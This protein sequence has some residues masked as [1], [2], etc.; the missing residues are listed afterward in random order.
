L[1]E[2]VAPKS[3]LK[4]PKKIKELNQIQIEKNQSKLDAYFRI[5]NQKV[6]NNSPFTE[7]KIER[8]LNNF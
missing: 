7:D 6:V 3:C 5:E 1:I 2:K 4:Q 8:Y